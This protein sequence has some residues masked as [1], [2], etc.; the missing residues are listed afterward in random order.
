MIKPD[1][2]A[3]HT[4]VVKEL[5]DKQKKFNSKEGE[6]KKF[7]IVF[8]DDYQAEWCPLIGLANTDLVTKGKSISFK[9]KYRKD[10]GDEIDIVAAGSVEEKKPDC[11]KQKIFNMHGHPVTIA[12]LAAKDIYINKINNSTK[13]DD[14]LMLSDMLDE[15]ETIYDWLTKKATEY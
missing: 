12:L 10:F 11:E 2:N 6:R 5:V 15:A 13:S 7:I 8:E 4:M 3:K 1:Q 14:D 9:I